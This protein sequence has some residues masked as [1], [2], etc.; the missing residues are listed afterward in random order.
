MSVEQD[1]RDLRIAEN[2]GY[3]FHR[4]SRISGDLGDGFRDFQDIFFCS[5]RSFA[6]FAV[7]IS[8]HGF[9]DFS[10]FFSS[11]SASSAV[12]SSFFCS[13]RFLAFFAVKALS[14]LSVK[15]FCRG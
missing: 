13:L 4:L 5:L 14:N 2:L 3:R 1:E 7:K 9:R 15:V 12:Q 11:F 10:W 6:Y 8:G